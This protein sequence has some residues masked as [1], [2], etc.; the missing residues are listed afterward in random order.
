MYQTL[1]ILQYYIIHPSLYKKC[2]CLPMYIM[3]DFFKYRNHNRTGKC[4]RFP[5]P[6]RHSS[7]NSDN[8]KCNQNGLSLDFRSTR[9]Y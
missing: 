1:K 9:N 5:A 7:F 2:I 4:K 6:V 3:K 8:L